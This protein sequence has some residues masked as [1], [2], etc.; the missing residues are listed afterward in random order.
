MGTVRLR[1][2]LW[3]WRDLSE[4]QWEA[5]ASPRP[6]LSI[7]W[8]CSPNCDQQ[9]G[10]AQFKEF[11]VK[12]KGVTWE[13]RASWWLSTSQLLPLP[14]SPQKCLRANFF[15]PSPQIKILTRSFW[16][17]GEQ[18]TSCGTLSGRV[19][20]GW[21]GLL[22]IKWDPSSLHPFGAPKQSVSSESL[23]PAR[24]GPYIWKSQAP[25]GVG[26]VWMVEEGRLWGAHPLSWGNG[27]SSSHPL[28]HDQRPSLHLCLCYLL[29]MRCSQQPAPQTS[30]LPALVSWPGACGLLAVK[31]TGWVP[32]PAPP[33]SSRLILGN[34]LSGPQFSLLSSEVILVL[35]A[36]EG[37]ED[38]PLVKSGRCWLRKPSLGVLTTTTTT[39]TTFHKSTVF[40][41]VT[42]VPL[43]SQDQFLVLGLT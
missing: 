18:W 14:S 11:R 28:S 36:H 8:G 6:Q 2:S 12:G 34:P 41:P 5:R 32:I 7:P 37:C 38:L 31:S 10:Q 27:I 23:R 4:P 35:T 15:P 21:A 19:C 42:G 29:S 20:R 22:D 40:K 9:G 3:L 13:S 17:R 33:H 43:G 26:E 1:G 30:Q 24:V 25:L 16:R 39:I